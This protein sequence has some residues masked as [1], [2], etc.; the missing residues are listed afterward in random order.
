MPAGWR[1]DLALATVAQAVTVAQAAT[2]AQDGVGC[3]MPG[4]C[5]ATVGR[6]A[7]FDF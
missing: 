3:I 7:A 5:R 2:V 4:T 6:R 1:G